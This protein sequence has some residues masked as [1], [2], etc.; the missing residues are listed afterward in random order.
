LN[1]LP[2]LQNPPVSLAIFIGSDSPGSFD[3]PFEKRKENTL[4]I[5]I[6]KL[7]MAGY[8]W[9]AFCGEQLYRNGMGRR[10][11]RLDETWLPDTVSSQDKGIIRNT[12]KVHIIRSKHTVK[13]IRDVRRAQQSKDRD[14]SVPS[15]FSFVME[16]LNDSP[17][18]NKPC[19]VAAL[20][21]DSHWDISKQVVVAHAALGGGSG[22][23]RLGIFGSH[24]LHAWPTSIEDIEPSMMNNTVTDT[25]Y[26]AND[27]NESGNWW[28][29]LNIGMGAM[30][31][32]NRF[33]LFKYIY[34][35]LTRYHF[36]LAS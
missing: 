14:D 17:L 28:K 4:D 32:I 15:L 19:H 8:I 2:L 23:T 18:F 24:L 20:I 1:Y 33:F 3:V 21:I 35:K 36:M 6:E 25:R 10:T 27:A 13:E 5:S 30:V 9:S 22:S 16:G 29:A 31:T 11:F 34:I 12:A 26:G 7:R